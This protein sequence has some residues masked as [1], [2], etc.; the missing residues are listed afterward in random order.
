MKTIALTLLLALVSLQVPEESGAAKSCLQ[1][2]TITKPIT[3]GNIT[4]FPLTSRVMSKTDYATLDEAMKR[5]WL[6]IREIGG[7]EVNFV[8]LKNTSDEMVLIMT[9]EM[10]S[11]AKQDRM[12]KDDVLIPPRS[13]WLRIPVFCVEHGRWVKVSRAFKS[14]GLVV[15]NELRQQARI[16]ENQSQVWDAIASSQD[17][18][19]IESSTGTALANYKDE[20]TLK[21]VAE[22]TKRLGDVSR[23]PKNTVG[24]C[25]T[26]GNR[27]TCVDIFANNDLLMKYWNK[28]LKSYVM[29]AIHASKSVIQ[30]EDIQDL[31]HALSH[32]DYVS[33]G[34]PGSGD[35]LRITTEFG[36]GSALIHEQNSIHMDFFVS[37]HY[38]EPSWRLDLRR[39]QR[40]HD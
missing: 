16:T 37:N 31:L 28:L 14:S 33:I 25:V 38:R 39:D 1:N 12:I 6:T 2:L 4:I 24:I 32:A 10:I 17:R 20:N 3:Y 34:T 19:G 36:K 29:D 30:H 35:L 23:L 15:P 21:E 9:G 40:L 18:L 26:T 13:N 5:N 11:G 22:Y 8:E 27:I 7:G